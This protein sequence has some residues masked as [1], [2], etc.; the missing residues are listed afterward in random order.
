MGSRGHNTIYRD[1]I[2]NGQRGRG[3]KKTIDKG[4]DIAWVGGQE[5]IDRSGLN[6]MGRGVNIFSS[7]CW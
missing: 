4:F 7:K 5:T 1:L 3:R 6:T 2:Y